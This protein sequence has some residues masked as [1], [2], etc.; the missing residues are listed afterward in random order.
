MPKVYLPLGSAAASGQ[1]G[2]MIVY[3]GVMVRAYV[4][5]TDPRTD[6]QLDVRHLFYDVT[7]MLKTLG[8]YGRGRLSGIFGPRWYTLAYKELTANGAEKML[9]QSWHWNSCTEV[10]KDAWR[11]A[12]PFA[13]TYSDPGELWMTMGLALQAWAF[14]QIHAALLDTIPTPSNTVAYLAAWLRSVDGVVTLS[15]TDDTDTRLLY[16][17]VWTEVSD[18]QAYFGSYHMLADNTK[19]MRFYFVGNRINIGFVGLPTGG[20][21]T[22]FVYNGL[23]EINIEQYRAVPTYGLSFAVDI[24][25]YGIHEIMLMHRGSSTQVITLDFLDAEKVKRVTQAPIEMPSP[26]GLVVQAEIDFGNVPT[27]GGVFDV[28]VQGAAVG[29][30]VIVLQAGDAATGR[31]QDENEMDAIILRGV[32][33]AGVVTVYADSLLG[34]VSGKYKINVLFG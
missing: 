16:G 8:L 19:A 5:P 13:A 29:Q 28:T 33:G 18:A 24:E 9:A 1:I 30:K 22:V 17:G 32:A 15:K 10:Q 31:D 23:H 4:V 6:A 20:T 26:V 14:V 7:K 34:V 2:E 27:F 21:M 12:A 3:Q 25:H 11:E